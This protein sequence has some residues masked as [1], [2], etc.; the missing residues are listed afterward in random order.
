[1]SHIQS[2]PVQTNVRFTLTFTITVKLSVTV[3][4]LASCFC[5]TLCKFLFQTHT[6][7]SGIC[8]LTDI[9]NATCVNT[10]G[11]GLYTVAH[12][13]VCNQATSETRMRP[14]WATT[15]KFL[16]LSVHSTWRPTVHR[17]WTLSV[18][19][20]WKAWVVMWIWPCWRDSADR[21]VLELLLKCW[22]LAWGWGPGPLGR[23]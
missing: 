3:Y 18:S 12:F 21:M 14:H 13:T 1:M 9:S 8:L 7:I 19:A 22:G 6:Q 16:L 10:I 15:P 23:K 2:T 11:R 5:Y 17:S 20:P 4:S